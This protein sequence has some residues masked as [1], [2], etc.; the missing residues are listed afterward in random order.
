MER[1]WS[2]LKGHDAKLLLPPS[3]GGYTIFQTSGSLLTLSLLSSVYLLLGVACIP[4]V[5]VWQLQ[6]QFYFISWTLNTN[7]WLCLL[8]LNLERRNLRIHY[9]TIE[10]LIWGQMCI[11]SQLRMYPSYINALLNGAR[12]EQFSR[13]KARVGIHNGRFDKIQ[14]YLFV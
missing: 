5:Q 12:T 14:Y 8:I 7:Y 3:L 2:P 6:S 4:C 10:C 11:S 13:R 9:K 1:T